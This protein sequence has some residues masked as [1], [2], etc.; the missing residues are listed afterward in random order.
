M[1]EDIVGLHRQPRVAQDRVINVM[2]PPPPPRGQ[3]LKKNV[4][5]FSPA[6]LAHA[7]RHCAAS[8]SHLAFKLAK[9]IVLGDC[10]AGK[11]AMV[12]R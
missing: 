1:C 7:E 6:T 10:G 3:H 4:E 9:M 11:T 12:Q 5:V 8:H 2:P